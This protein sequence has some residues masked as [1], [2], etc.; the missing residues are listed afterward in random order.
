MMPDY[1][2]LAPLFGGPLKPHQVDGVS[3]IVEY[4]HARRMSRLWLAYVLATVW[5]ETGRWM[6]PIREGALRYGPAYTD[7]QS[8][9]AVAAIHAKGIIRTN[10]AL[11]DGP[12]KQSYYG[13]G[14]VQIT[15]YDN[16]KKFEDDLGIPLTQ[17]PDL[18]LDWN[19]S[20]PITFDGM[21]KGK[22]TNK[23]LSMILSTDDYTA[24]RAII[25]G[26]TKTNGKAIADAAVAFYNALA[27]YT[28]KPE[29]TDESADSARS[30][31]FPAW[32]PF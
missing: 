16:Y 23:S 24:A 22:F 18:A 21:L 7:A 14:L 6:Q 17:Y 30:K 11:P 5:H 19:Y 1:S 20:L 26:D 9:R 25:N 12:Y 31:W 10:Y 32:W 8:K 3:R 15:W 29:G 28:P 2:I 4:A 27:D 13:R